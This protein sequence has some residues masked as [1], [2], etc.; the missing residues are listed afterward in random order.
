MKKKS[1]QA[2]PA[3]SVEQ[4]K[5]ERVELVPE[6][7]PMDVAALVKILTEVERGF[8]GAT[9]EQAGHCNVCSVSVTVDYTSSGEV[10]AVTVQLYS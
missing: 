4:K 3:K 6:D 7:K 10:G 2:A 9:V 1:E 5:Q 8:P